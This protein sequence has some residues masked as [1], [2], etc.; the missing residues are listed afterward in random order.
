MKPTEEVGWRGG[1][2]ISG[3]GLLCARPRFPRC[4][5]RSPSRLGPVS[6][7]LSPI[8]ISP[9]VPFNSLCSRHH[10]SVTCA[11][12]LISS[13]FPRSKKTRLLPL[14]LSTV[15][16]GSCSEAA[17]PFPWYQPHRQGHIPNLLTAHSPIPLVHQQSVECRRLNICESPSIIQL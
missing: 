2:K 7:F 14:L 4:C 15:K 5:R 16:P 12:Y 13:Q 6:R 3:P 8:P 17:T 1:K 10:L 11:R 9:A